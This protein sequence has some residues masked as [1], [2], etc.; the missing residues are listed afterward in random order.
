MQIPADAQRTVFK[1][2]LGDIH[3][4]ARPDALIG[5]WFDGQTHQPGLSH[6]PVVTTNP[7]LKQTE[8]QLADYFAGLRERFDLPIAIVFGSEFQR[9]VWAALST[10][11]Y[12]HTRSYQDIAQTLQKPKAVRA[13]GAAIGKNP[14]S[15]VI[16]CHRVLGAKGQLTGYAGGLD[17]KAALLHLEGVF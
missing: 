2:P 13:V 5:L 8:E 12:G 6:I 15:L 16:P 17:R 7:V 1:S 4:L 3:L 10:I 9:T 11:T 14:L